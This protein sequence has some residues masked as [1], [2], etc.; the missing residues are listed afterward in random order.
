MLQLPPF[1][2]FPVDMLAV[3]SQVHDIFASIIT[4]ASSLVLSKIRTA[5]VHLL[6]FGTLFSFASG[7]LIDF[8]GDWWPRGVPTFPLSDTQPTL[9]DWQA[10]KG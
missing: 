6:S 2:H 9:L 10:S 8:S 5:L 4:R 3:V 1:N 7:R